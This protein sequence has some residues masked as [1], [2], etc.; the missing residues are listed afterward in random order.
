[1]CELK[2]YSLHV[3]H[4]RGRDRGRGE[5]EREGGRGGGR[6]ISREEGESET[7][8]ASSCLHVLVHV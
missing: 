5:R 2:L 8:L 4:E 3:P 1:M 6:E 7:Y